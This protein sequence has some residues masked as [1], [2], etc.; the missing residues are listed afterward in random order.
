MNFTK[1]SQNTGVNL[2]SEKSRS[3]LR[4]AFTHKSYSRECNR[5]DKYPDNER[6]EFFGD[7]V[8]EFAVS[9]Y[10]FQSFPKKTEGELTKI[11]SSVV[12]ESSLAKFA[13]ELDFGEF[14]Y[15]GKGE[16]KSG[17]RNRQSLLAD[18]FEAFVG[19]LYFDQGME[20]IEV[21]LMRTVFAKIDKGWISSIVDVKSRLQELVQRAHAGN[22]EYKITNIEGPS[23]DRIFSVAV[24]LG[25]SCLGKGSGHSKKV[26]QQHAALHALNNWQ[27]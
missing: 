7:S 10:L 22:L 13:N 1:L 8:L 14:V 17:G 23:H 19:A 27:L 4:Q 18:L 9:K 15:L 2:S 12:C 5:Q 21:F 11:K 25:E 16:E 20:A 24:Y 6:L 3:L 26:A